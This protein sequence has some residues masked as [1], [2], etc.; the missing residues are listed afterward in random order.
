MG[1]ICK[2]LGISIT[3]AFTIFTRK[4]IRDK[5]ILFSIL[6]DPFYSNENISALQNLIDKVKK[7]K[8]IMKSIEELETME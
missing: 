8:I 7:G 3:I 2:D 6:I 4:F 1:I 5:S